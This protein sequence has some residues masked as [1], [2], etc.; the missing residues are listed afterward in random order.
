MENGVYGCLRTVC[1]LMAHSSQCSGPLAWLQREWTGEAA[2]RGKLIT[3]AISARKLSEKFRQEG[4]RAMMM[5]DLL[6]FVDPTKKPRFGG[7]SSTKMRV[8]IEGPS[9][10]WETLPE[11]DDWGVTADQVEEAWSPPG[12]Y[13]SKY[14]PLSSFLPTYQSINL[15]IL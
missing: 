15:Y 11:R 1:R 8:L 3:N 10:A 2:E 9:V 5:F 13:A 7:R 14:V 12:T 4:K 6:P